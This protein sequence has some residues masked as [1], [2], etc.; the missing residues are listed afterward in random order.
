MDET[1]QLYLN[2]IVRMTLPQAYQNQV[3]HIQESTKF[4]HPPVGSSQVLPFPG[5]TI[6]TPPQV[7]NPTNNQ[8]YQD[9]YSYQRQLLELP[10]D[11]DLITPL[12]LESFHLT[13]ADLIWDSAY[14][15]ACDRHPNYES[16]LQSCVSKIFQ[17]YHHQYPQLKTPIRWSF[18]GLIVMSRAVGIALVPKDS[19][20]YEQI[21]NLRRLIYQDPQ[22]IGLGIEQHYHFTAHITLGYFRT[23]PP[24]LERDRLVYF[25]DAL[26]QDWL[27]KTPDFIVNKAELRKFDDMNSFYRQPDWPAIDFN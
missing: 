12:P 3:Q 10:L 2:R 14:K 17:Q 5:Y 24:N 13:L 25:L 16:D 8:F 21:I 20:D 7:D 22:L 9:L 15:N 27:G 26:N 6:I 23:I 11:V 4:Y 18:A 19:S 1:Y